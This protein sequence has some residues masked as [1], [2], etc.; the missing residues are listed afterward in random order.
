LK[1]TLILGGTQ[2]I[3]RNLVE[4]LQALPEYDITLFN[5]QQ[6][7]A[8]LFPNLKRIKGD[9]ETDDIHQIG[10]QDWDYII[11]LSCYYPNS[12]KNLLSC[13]TNK[14][15]KYIYVS[16][17][18]VY[19]NANNQSELKSENAAVLPCNSEQCINRDLKTYGNRKAECERILRTSMVN[20]TILRPSLVYGKY[21]HTDRFY[22][23]LHQVKTKDVLLLPDNGE[24]KFSLTYVHDL[25]NAIISALKVSASETYNITT[26][27]Q[28][29]IQQIV[30]TAKT[31][32]NAAQKEVNA[33]P[34]FLDEN[35]IS[36]WVN[37]PL[38]INGDYFTYSNQKIKPELGFVPTSMKQSISETISYYDALG[39]KEP[40]YGISEKVRQELI[41]KITN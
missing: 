28:A 20:H 25:V 5:R 22:Y 17:C 32:L 41:Q 26:V 24:R 31:Q 11:D 35:E 21:D 8:D 40:I 7:Q 33:T 14:P 2:F 6:T 34:A 16:T 29:S 10:N 30:T 36:Q 27:P 1:K 3:G 12:L 18:S 39:W 15:E 19:D 38:W 23:W 37:M 13:L 9:R 4:K